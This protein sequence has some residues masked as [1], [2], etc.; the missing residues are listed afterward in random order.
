M[1]KVK[2]NKNK[3]HALMGSY[4]SLENAALNLACATLENVSD[5]VLK[6]K[7]AVSEAALP[8][9]SPILLNFESKF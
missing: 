4:I 5:R 7:E 1:E 2:I 9:N 8:Q 3:F 6:V